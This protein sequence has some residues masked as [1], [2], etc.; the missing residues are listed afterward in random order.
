MAPFQTFLG[1]MTL[2]NE[3]KVK[4]K[5]LYGLIRCMFGGVYYNMLAN[6]IDISR[7]NSQG[8]QFW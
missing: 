7:S 1:Q 2:K 8:H 3:I 5:A 6:K 4:F